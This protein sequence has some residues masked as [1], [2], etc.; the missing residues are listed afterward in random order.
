MRNLPHRPPLAGFAF[1]SKCEELRLSK[2]GPVCSN[3]RTSIRRGVISLMGH[4]QSFRPLAGCGAVAARQG[5]D[6]LS[7]CARLC[8]DVDPA[9][10]LFD[11]DVMGH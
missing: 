7:K 10:V 8:L 3:E 9:A 6:K 11:N 4:K 5:N 2:S 1:G